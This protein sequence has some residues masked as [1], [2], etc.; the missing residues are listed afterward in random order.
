MKTFQYF[1]DDGRSPILL[2]KDGE[3]P[4]KGFRKSEKSG[5]RRGKDSDGQFFLNPRRAMLSLEEFEKSEQGL[6]F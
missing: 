2:D 6:W 1:P 4:R 3:P 5:Y